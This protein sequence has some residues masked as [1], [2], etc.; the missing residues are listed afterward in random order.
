MLPTPGCEGIL[1]PGQEIAGDPS[2]DPDPP[3]EFPNNTGKFLM[4]LCSHEEILDSPTK[5]NSFFSIY[6]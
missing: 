4:G 6:L 3:L 1:R 2:S 5:N